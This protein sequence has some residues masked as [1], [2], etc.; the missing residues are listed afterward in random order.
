LLAT[1]GGLRL[2]LCAVIY[3]ISPRA[4]YRVVYLY[5]AGNSRRRKTR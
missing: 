3:H 2:E 1:H 4:L 5:R